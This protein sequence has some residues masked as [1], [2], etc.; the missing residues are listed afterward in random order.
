MTFVQIGEFDTLSG[1]G[2]GGAK[3]TNFRKV[4]LKLGMHAEDINFNKSCVF[5]PVE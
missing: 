3:R 2:G 1:G 5:I 4:S